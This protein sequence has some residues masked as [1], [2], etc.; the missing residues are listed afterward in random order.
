MAAVSS[1]DYNDFVER[2]V[3]S[4]SGRKHLVADLADRLNFLNLNLHF[5]GPVERIANLL[6]DESFSH[7]YEF[8]MRLANQ[9]HPRLSQLNLNVITDM[10]VNNYFNERYPVYFR[11]LER[12]LGG[13]KLTMDRLEN[14]VRAMVEKDGHYMVVKTCDLELRQ[15]DPDLSK[16]LKS[17]E[18][19]IIS[20]KQRLVDDEDINRDLI[21]SEHRK[22]VENE[23]KGAGDIF[24]KRVSWDPELEKYLPLY[25]EPMEEDTETVSNDFPAGETVQPAEED[26]EEPPE[27]DDTSTDE[28]VPDEGNAH[29]VNKES[30]GENFDEEQAEEAPVSDEKIEKYAE[31][32]KARY[33][34]NADASDPGA[35]SKIIDGMYKSNEKT[36]GE[37]TAEYIEKEILVRWMDDESIPEE[38]KDAVREKLNDHD[39]SMPADAPVSLPDDFDE[40]PEDNEYEEIET[41][42]ALPEE[43]TMETEPVFD[44]TD[45]V[46]EEPGF[47]D[48][49]DNDD[50]N[51]E[52]DLYSEA[53]FARESA[54]SGTGTAPT[55]DSSAEEKKGF[56]IAD[57]VPFDDKYGKRSFEEDVE[58]DE[59]RTGATGENEKEEWLYQQGDYVPEETIKKPVESPKEDSWLYGEDRDTGINEPGASGN[60]ADAL[61][62]DYKTE[63]EAAGIT[64]D[65]EYSFSDREPAA[66]YPTEPEGGETGRESDDLEVDEPSVYRVK[67][68]VL[69]N[70]KGSSN[71]SGQTEALPRDHAESSPSLV[72]LI[73]DYGK[74]LS[75][76]KIAET[77]RGKDIPEKKREE[78]S[79]VLKRDDFQK[80]FNYI[81]RSIEFGP[82]EKIVLLEKWLLV[83]G[84]EKGWFDEN[85]DA[86]IH[87]IHRMVDYY[88]TFITRNRQ[89]GKTA[90][91][92]RQTVPE[93]ESSRKSAE[94]VP[95]NTREKRTV[96]PENDQESREI[97]DD[98]LTEQERIRD[99]IIN[100]ARAFSDSIETVKPILVKFAGF[101][102]PEQR[103]PVSR[104]VSDIERRKKE[105]VN[106]TVEMVKSKTPDEGLLEELQKVPSTLQYA[107]LKGVKYGL[108]NNHT[109]EIFSVFAKDKDFF[110][111]LKRILKIIAINNKG[112]LLEKTIQWEKDLLKEIQSSL[113]IE[114]L[115]Q[116]WLKT[117]NRKNKDKVKLF[118]ELMDL[119][120]ESVPAGDSGPPSEPESPYEGIIDEMES[121]RKHHGKKQDGDRY[122]RDVDSI[123]GFF[124]DLSSGGKEAVSVVT[125]NRD[126]VVAFLRYILKEE[127][128]LRDIFNIREAIR[129]CRSNGIL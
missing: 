24:E 87:K 1:I 11:I 99:L 64:A 51:E 104:V 63:D 115:K 82:E 18:L 60:T 21:R 81:T 36:F 128:E 85:R 47:D 49:A 120:G 42:A 89:S 129:Y 102:E 116:L 4:P 41:G 59:M 94:S 38:M 107:W 122:E 74:N 61:P 28:T 76:D 92:G 35:I 127:P 97:K 106:R 10:I 13:R 62:D 32:I 53:D 111:D 75:H 27:E 29:A 80:A 48:V 22:L 50:F 71:G 3:N 103:G 20:I 58:K 68:E 95:V 44:E 117:Q 37:D 43:T 40:I 26:G 98:G 55:E 31:M 88:R 17:I 33:L 119:T 123:S 84:E 54:P 79:F 70:R 39:E 5:F 15:Y 78:L 96:K 67:G 114:K 86:K 100:I 46:N 83:H 12:D 57:E 77:T 101:L 93:S 65:G 90:M 8:R 69:F 25:D 105:L 108:K 30:P 118:R 91:T 6:K 109:D 72:K 73:S 16:K 113:S 125:A 19:I 7:F 23:G 124:K 2:F 121:F 14:T 9:V 56:Q 34:L 112:D 66:A 110:S 126:S 52:E 45:T